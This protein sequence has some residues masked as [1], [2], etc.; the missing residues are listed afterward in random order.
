M[1][2]SPRRRIMH[3]L[4]LDAIAAVDLPCQEHA[5][6]AIMKRAYTADERKTMAESGEALPDG[7]FPIKTKADL[8]NAIQAVGRA[9]DPAKAKRHIRTRAKALDAEDA[10]PE[11]WASKSAAE[12]AIEKL[13]L[14]DLPAARGF[15]EILACE[16]AQQRRWAANDA[17]WP[18]FDAL[19]ESLVS[20]GGD[21]TLDPGAKLTMAQQSVT[22]FIGSLSEKWSDVAAAVDQIAKASP[23]ADRMAAFI[24]AGKA[25]IAKKEAVMADIKEADLTK[26]AET[27]ESDNPVIKALIDAAIAKGKKAAEPDADDMMEGADGKP[28]KKG[29]AFIAKHQPADADEILK[30]GDRSI[31]KSVVGEDQFAIF[32]AQQEELTKARDERELAKLEKRAGDEFSALPGTDSEIALVLKHMASAPEAVRKSADAIFTAAQKNKGAFE[33]I[34]KSGRK[35]GE[36]GGADAAIT[37]RAEF[38]GKVSEIA[39]RDGI[40]RADAM[41][42]ARRE[43]PDL[44]K[45]AY[46]SPEDE[47]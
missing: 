28:T 24:T 12:D 46:P 13:G 8:H 39:K 1:S 31:R 27:L 33:S 45:E 7:S 10:I 2:M 38:G 15:A 16:E 36:G 11:G 23:N 37:K 43:Y 5:K 3:S 30:V 20:I 22:Q 25:G 9:A 41:G 42:K 4:T 44:Y 6:M 18:L 19:R 32:K 14:A 34:G 29:L 35:G 40:G 47:D 17:L 21:D 26:A